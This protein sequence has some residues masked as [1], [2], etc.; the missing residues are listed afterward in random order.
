MEPT[1]AAAMET[2]SRYHADHEIDW[3]ELREGDL[4]AQL[5]CNAREEVALRARLDDLDQEN[6]DLHAQLAALRRE[7]R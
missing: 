2:A 5:D 6:V 7:P 3:H 1:K 4:L